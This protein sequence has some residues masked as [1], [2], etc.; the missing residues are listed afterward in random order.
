MSGLILLVIVGAWLAVLVP[1]AL[2]SHD[3]GRALSTVDKFHDAMR[4][5]SRR[6]GLVGASGAG[7]D[8]S[9]RGPRP[10]RPPGV[11]APR[12]QAP[13][14]A[15]AGVSLAV[16]RRRVLLGLVTTAA[17]TL[18]GAL[19]GPRWMIGVHAFADLLALAYVVHLR[20]QQVQRAAR[21]WRDAL[22]VRGPAEVPAAR[23]ARGSGQVA[24]PHRPATRAAAPTTVRYAAPARVAGIPDRMPARPA[25]ALAPVA[26]TAD[27]G[28]VPVRGA[29][30]EPW[31]PVPVP[32]PGYVTAPTAPRRVLDL[33]RPGQ[34]SDGV[35]VAERRARTAVREEAPDEVVGRRRAAGDW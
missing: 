21:Q 9:P 3:A 29:V 14:R 20:H 31:A 11:P 2:R 22:D 23:P 4:V 6:D 24:A 19:L 25:P 35:A 34:W 18:A 13:G 7:P 28:P 8:G 33:T 30:G 17:V 32:L 26:V 15:T 1:M 27:P 16:R 10:P 5:L 12:P